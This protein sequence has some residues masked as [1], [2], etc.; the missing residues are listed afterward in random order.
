[1]NK[2]T[3]VSIFVFSTLLILVGVNGSTRTAAAQDENEF[4]TELSG[5]SVVPPEDTQA[6]G[7]AEFQ[8]MGTESIQYNI[9]ATNIQ[10][11]TSGQIHEGIEGQNGA[12]LVELFFYD[13]PMNQVSESGTITEDDFQGGATTSQQQFTD[14]IT[15]M[16]AGGAYVSIS[17]EQNPDGETR[18]QITG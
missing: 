9:N 16:R 15:A 13:A 3:A 18:G 2:K 5:Q 8:V 7:L 10:N 14:F 17:T 11:V 12:M 1:M 6:T 4:T